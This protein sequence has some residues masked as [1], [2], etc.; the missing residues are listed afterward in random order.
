MSYVQH[1]LVK[2]R[3]IEA[4]LY[5][6]VIFDAATR[7]N[8]LVVLPTGLGKTQIAVMLAAH[9]LSEPPGSKVLV[10]AP[11][12]P[13][14]LQ[15]RRTFERTLDL[16]GDS[17][18]VLTGRVP[19]SQRAGIWERAQLAF[20]T[21]QVVERDIIAGR[22]PLEDFS[23]VVFDEA[24]RAVGNYPYGFIAERYMSAAKS[25]LI[26]GLTASPGGEAEKVEEVKEN[27][28]IQHVET[29]T[30]RDS[31]VAPY[32]QPVEVEWRRLELPGPV[33]EIKTVLEGRLKEQLRELKKYGFLRSIQR[34]SKRELL[35][36]Q[37]SIREA[38]QEHGGSPPSRFY[39]ALVA[40]AAA[41]RLCHAIE[42]LE[43]QGLESLGRYLSGLA[44][45]AGKPGAPKSAKL[46]MS[47]SQIRRVVEIVDDLK[48]RLENPKIVEA[49][50]IL[51]AQFRRNP[52]SRTIV[53]SHYRDSADRLVKA[54][55]SVENVRPV[56][57]I[58]QASREG[59]RGLSQKDQAEILD[60]FRAGEVNV[61]VSTAV[62]EEG[63]DIPSVD[64]VLFYEAVPSGIRLIQRRG[65]TGRRAPGRMIALL[66]KGTRDEAFYWSAVHKERRMREA[67]SEASGEAAAEVGQ[68]MLDEFSGE[69]IKVIADHRETA[70][71]V[72]RELTRLGV[73]VEIRQLD[74]GDFILSERVGVER[75][76]A[77]DFLQSMI[78]KRLM[79]QAKQ[80]TE[81]FE[82]P[83][84]ILEGRGLYS[85][86]GIHPNAIRGA[87]AS[88]AVD[89][90]IPILPARDEKETARLLFSIA[91]RE[92]AGV[93]R[94]I[95]IRGVAK[96]LTLPEQQRFIV[97]G[98]PGVSAVLAKRLL[99]H[100]GTVERVV[101]ASED[102]LKEV[103]GIGKEK[104]K[105]IR[106][107]LSSEYE[108]EEES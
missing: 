79:D 89:Y 73:E 8:T 57:F 41:F 3:S 35:Q 66:A 104:A 54:L 71:G 68:K 70:S 4:R 95:P 91:R 12:R 77:G 24:H 25:P 82:R 76:S 11:T 1:P 30:E 53:F 52:D 102:E 83:V 40:Q 16:P 61:L 38:M 50:K 19:P 17:L 88:L 72:V 33:V 36:V 86:R 74:V 5:Q 44:R 15:H 18:Q 78:D 93:A 64:L 97:E 45:K 42:L 47:D 55:G 6:Q 29:R 101:R 98:L 49:R 20:A 32:I 92:Q 21:P 23:L 22:L 48:G 63:L 31:D 2:P 105:E 14:T 80:L 59:D 60:R 46:L 28:F 85:R 96:G 100:F 81:T 27:L 7:E 65:R 106:R 58:G 69:N 13:L 75:K 107:V 26:L 90:H 99:E 56:K 67:L 9:R 10:I 34:V 87:L 94:E 37:M 108:S 51:K 43:T 84:L 39:A 62:G 103:H